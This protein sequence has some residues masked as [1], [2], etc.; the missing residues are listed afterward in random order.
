[1]SCSWCISRGKEK[2]LTGKRLAVWYLIVT[3]FLLWYVF[4]IW[5]HFPGPFTYETWSHTQMDVWLRAITYAIAYILVPV[6]W[7]HTRGF[8]RKKLISSLDRRRDIRIII[9]YRCV[10][11]FGPI[12]S[13]TDFLWLTVFQYLQSIPLWVFVNSLGAWLPVIIMMHVIFIPRIAVLFKW[14]FTVIALWWLYYALFSLFDQGVDYSTFD[15]VVTSVSYIIMTQTIIG[16]WK[17]AFTVVTWNPFI[18]YM[19]LHVLSARI[20]FDTKMYTEIFNIWP[21]N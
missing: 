12:F 16:M 9:V 2:I 21:K 18:H 7:L 10:D 20:P 13:W 8:S 3:Q 14:K 19:T 6:L 11:F 15:T 1:V 17:A 4:E 5:L